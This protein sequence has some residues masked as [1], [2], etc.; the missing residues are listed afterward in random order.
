M[1]PVGMLMEIYRRSETMP[2]VTVEMCKR[3]APSGSRTNMRESPE[4]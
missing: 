4:Q 1:D 2:N 3:T